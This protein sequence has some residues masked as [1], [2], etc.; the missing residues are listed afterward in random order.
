MLRRATLNGLQTTYSL[1]LRL[2]GM[3]CRRSHCYRIRSGLKA[4]DGL[5]LG[6]EQACRVEGECLDCVRLVRSE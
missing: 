6:R 4:F 2:T 5:R 1:R 3:K